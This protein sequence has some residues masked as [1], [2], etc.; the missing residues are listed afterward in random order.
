MRPLH[1]CHP[2]VR[3]RSLDTGNINT[4][5]RLDQGRDSPTI[6][7]TVESKWPGPRQRN[8]TMMD[9]PVTLA[10]SG[11]QKLDFFHS[12]NNQ[13]VTRLLCAPDDAPATL[14]MMARQTAGQTNHRWW[15]A[16]RHPDL[17]LTMAGTQSLHDLIF[18]PRRNF[19]NKGPK[20]PAAMHRRLHLLLV[21]RGARPAAC[22]PCA[23]SKHRPGEP[24]NKRRA[25]ARDM[26]RSLCGGHG[27]QQQQTPHKILP[28][29]VTSR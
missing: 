18:S 16:L 11:L 20:K 4:I 15:P 2:S 5:H 6:L 8:L 24:T 26:R 13:Q 21:Q 14:A 22:D 27:W 12:P 28:G 25:P 17:T 10:R 23:I 3:R 1:A 19:S 7:E 29:I 9:G